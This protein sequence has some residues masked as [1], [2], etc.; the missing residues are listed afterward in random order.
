F[1]FYAADTHTAAPTRPSL[2]DS[3][4]ISYASCTTPAS[5]TSLAAG[6]HTFA[7]KAT[8][9]AGNTDATPASFSWFVDTTPPDTS[10]TAQP[11]D[12]TNGSAAGC[13]FVATVNRTPAAGLTLQ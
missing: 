8:D 7:V 13:T 5:Y 2:H 10:I 6:G 1:D 3:L 4:P 9:Q 11:T 12:P